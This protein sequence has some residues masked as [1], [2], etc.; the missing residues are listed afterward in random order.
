[1]SPLRPA[2][3]RQLTKSDLNLKVLGRPVQRQLAL[4]FDW[5]EKATLAQFQLINTAGQIVWQQP[6]TVLNGENRFDFQLPTLASATYFLRVQTNTA[7]FVETISVV[8]E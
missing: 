3:T 7:F 1:M 2:N 4:Q 8:Q 5:Q 6:T